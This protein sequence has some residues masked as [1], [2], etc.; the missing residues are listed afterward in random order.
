MKGKC[1]KIL[2]LVLVF[3]MFVQLFT[4][5]GSIAQ[6]VSATSVTI[7]TIDSRSSASE[8]WLT[9]NSL[10]IDWSWTHW[11]NNTEVIINGTTSVKANACW[12]VDTLFYMAPNVPEGMTLESIT[13]NKGTQFTINGNVYEIQNDFSAYYYDNGWH[14]TPKVQATE[15]AINA[16]DSRSVFENDLHQIYLATNSVGVTATWS[17]GGW[18]NATTVKLN[19]TTDVVANACWAA[20]TLIYI[21][22]VVPS[23]VELESITISKGTLFTMTSGIYEISA[24]FTL[25]YYDGGYH[26]VPKV[27]GTPV[28]INAIDNRSVFENDLHQIYLATNSVGVTATWADGGWDNATTVKLNG[29]TDVVANACWAA[30]TLIYIQPVVP[31]GV[32]LESITISKGTLFTMTSGIYEISADFTLYYYDGGY[33][34]TA[35][36]EGTP[37]TITGI[38]QGETAT[39][40][41][42]G[43]YLLYLQTNQVSTQGWADGGWDHVAQVY[44][45]GTAPCTAQAIW[46]SNTGELFMQPVIPA[47]VTTVESILIKEGTQFSL[48]GTL[49]EITDDY[50]IYYKN[51]VFSDS[52]LY[53]ITKIVDGETTTETVA[54]DYELPEIAKAGYITLGWDVNGQLYKTGATLPAKTA[55]Y[56]ITAVYAAFSQIGGAQVRLTTK[57]ENEQVGGMRFVCKLGNDSKSKHIV[58]MGI[59]VMPTDYMTNGE[60][61]HDNYGSTNAQGTTKGYREFVVNNADMLLEV[62]T[63]DTAANGAEGYYLKGSIVNLNDYNYTRSYS[64]RSFLKV[65]YADGAE[66]IYTDYD[67][68]DNAR[69][70]C[71]IAKKMIETYPERYAPIK[72][73]TYPIVYEYA[74]VADTMESFA[75]FGPEVVITNNVYDAAATKAAMQEYAATGFKYLWLDSVGYHYHD[76]YSASSIEN[77]QSIYDNPSHPSFDLK[78]TMEIAKECGLDVIVLDWSLRQLSVCD[79]PLVNA[80]ATNRQVLGLWLQTG[81]AQTVELIGSEIDESKFSADGTTYTYDGANVTGYASGQA[82]VLNC[83]YQFASEEALEE[84]VAIKM[85]AY[86]QEDNFR[87]VM[88]ADEPTIAV[89]DQLALMTK[90]IKKLYPNAYVQNSNLP[91]YGYQ[92]GSGTLWDPYNDGYADWSA[93]NGAWKMLLQAH[94]NAQSNVTETGIN[95]YPFARWSHSGGSYTYELRDHY[96]A[97]LQFLANTMGDAGINLEFT[98]QSYAVEK[99]YAEVSAEKLALQAN[100]ALAFGTKTLAYF[101]YT[102]AGEIEPGSDSWE[103][104]QSINSDADLKNAVFN[105][106]KNGNYLK[107]HMTFFEYQASKVFGDGSYV[108][109]DE[110]QQS[111]ALVNEIFAV[112][113]GA[114][115]LVNEFYNEYTGQYGYYV[116][117]LAQLND[118]NGNETSNADITITLSEACFV[119]QNYKNYTSEKANKVS[120]VTLSDGQGAF[121]VVE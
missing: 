50:T 36:V 32:E 70:I 40:F 37:T 119:Y 87:G 117:N 15:I 99:L 97:S 61:N 114:T 2:S 38:N 53:D 17:D 21:Q 25:Y 90:V 16:I 35:K 24:D 60:L 58:Q 80:N 91:C 19:G 71:D 78:Q 56:T 23:G 83:V 31:S 100:L 49:Y 47:D 8:L 28:T 94:A 57:N 82:R 112:S 76:R 39:R 10:G 66:Y 33:H 92:S 27:S 22:P 74:K 29:T 54:G 77:E 121:I 103:I 67:K 96:L 84:W 18:D 44:I 116:V 105:A 9:T 30:D 65:E 3:A 12:V 118:K 73:Q 55:G 11:D 107:A 89:Y 81:D 120:S 68:D 85:S 48:L 115:V 106:N 5:L 62:Y 13:I 95:F 72:N 26:N 42:N 109:T 64:A 45:N 111:S 4:G 59:L 52:M 20:D 7:N 113:D 101:R 79:I 14:T 69:K 1:K 108:S 86:A 75:F 110:L 34:D 6:A 43:N 51:G 102:G 104:E 93:E 98:I 41:E 63:P 88:L 46:S